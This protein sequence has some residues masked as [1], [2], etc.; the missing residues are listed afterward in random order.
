MSSPPTHPQST[1]RKRR[2]TT[3]SVDV[4]PVPIMM[5]RSDLI[6]SS[7]DLKKTNRKSEQGKKKSKK[8]KEDSKDKKKKG[9]KKAKKEGEGST[10]VKR[11]GK[12]KRRLTFSQRT[13]GDVLS[14]PER[15]DGIL[16]VEIV[17]GEMIGE[18]FVKK[19]IYAVASASFGKQRFKTKVIKKTSE[20]TWER[21][22][23]FFTD[24][25]E[26]SE[27]YINLFVTER[28]KSEHVGTV[29]IDLSALEYEQDHDMW[30]DMIPIE[31]KKKNEESFESRI[32][33]KIYYN[34]TESDKT[35]DSQKFE[36]IYELGEE[37]GSFFL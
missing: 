10:K 25:L 36:D 35:V 17:E 29:T 4:H 24:Q 16:Y 1:K 8:G 26:R 32:H 19:G 28:H 31:H 30:V 13:E 7:T 20:P 21:D 3:S 9:H 23:Q 18:G 22:C 5:S 12:G 34:N 15:L 27:L 37:I 2:S 33:V 6:R 14:E 11:R